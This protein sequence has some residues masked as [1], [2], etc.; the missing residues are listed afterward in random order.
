[1]PGN[2]DCSRLGDYSN[3][4]DVNIGVRADAVMPW[5]KLWGAKRCIE[6]EDHD[7]SLSRNRHAVSIRGA[8]LGALFS[9]RDDPAAAKPSNTIPAGRNY[10]EGGGAKK[11]R[12]EPFGRRQ[13]QNSPSGDG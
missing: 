4:I 1:M 3:N 11:Q 5:S 6:M 9:T 13:R 12:R 8:F 7:M 10:V 2:L